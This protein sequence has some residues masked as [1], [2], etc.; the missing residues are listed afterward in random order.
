MGA[1]GAGIQWRSYTP[2]QAMKRYRVLKTLLDS[3]VLTSEELKVA[4]I[5]LGKF[6]R[7]SR[8]SEENVNIIVSEEADQFIDRL[9][10]AVWEMSR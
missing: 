7:A 6:D 3:K 1:R 10:E 2:E 9:E 5:L 8:S 4:K